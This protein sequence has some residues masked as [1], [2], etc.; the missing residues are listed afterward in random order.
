MIY[1][2]RIMIMR[3]ACPMRRA[4]AACT[5]GD[6]EYGLGTT[7]IIARNQGLTAV[8]TCIQNMPNLTKLCV[9][10]IG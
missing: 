1:A 6:K 3:A 10:D 9:P 8:P 4:A 5:I 7:E 2:L